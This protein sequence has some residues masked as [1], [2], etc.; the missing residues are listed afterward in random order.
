MQKIQSFL[1]KVIT[2][3][4]TGR[5]ILTLILAFGCL[6]VCVASAMSWIQLS[7]LGTVV[8][9]ITGLILLEWAG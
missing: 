7:L 6:A 8:V 3:N 2:S 5:R 4:L 1:S 9:L